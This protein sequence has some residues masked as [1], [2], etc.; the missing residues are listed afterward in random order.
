[1]KKWI[2]LLNWK[3]KIYKY[4]WGSLCLYGIFKFF[5]GK[6]YKVVVIGEKERY[7]VKKRL[8]I[9]IKY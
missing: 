8:V 2:N 6:G 7:N 5:D 9:L 1:M 3:E 4:F